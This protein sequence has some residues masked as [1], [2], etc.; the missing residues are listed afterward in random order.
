MPALAL[1]SAL[2]IAAAL[3]PAVLMAHEVQEGSAP[4]E[5]SRRCSA[6][7]PKIYQEWEGSMHSKSSLHKDQAHRVMYGVFLDDM[8]K[9][10]KVGSY[11]CASCHMPMAE[12]IKEL[13]DGTAQPNE[14]LWRE[15]EGVGCAFCHRVEAII[16]GK[17]RNMFKINKDGAYVSS[18]PPEKAPHT[19]GANPLFASGELC[20]GCHSHLK[21]QGGM[22]ICSMKE[23]GQSDCLSCHM[24]RKEGPPSI[25]SLKPDHASH[26]MGGGHNLEMLKK[27]ATVQ[28]NIN[29]TEKGKTIDIEITNKTAH[30]F[31]STMPMRMAFLK[32]AFYDADKKA[33]FRNYQKNPMEDKKAVFMKAFKG[34]G[35]V[36][37]PAWK[38]EGVA[39]DT[40]LKNGEVR[41]YSYPITDDGVKYISVE[42]MYR[43]F[44]PQA[45]EKYPALKE[46]DG[47]VND[48][49][50]PIYKKDFKL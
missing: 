23:E 22:S 48:K 40:R 5:K 21:T 8:K 14:N 27:A 11:H 1:V 36:G 29:E 46:V 6:C 24:D 38:A 18:N 7:H 12:N 45:T 30:D 2:A 33:I 50:I 13:M 4:Y 20:M 32:V 41:T 17:D 37:V 44:P 34:G 31:P 16:E 43:L 47:S 26:A 39:F 10:G 42:L 9:L 49:A 25:E 3:F 19:V 35:E 28:A 15:S